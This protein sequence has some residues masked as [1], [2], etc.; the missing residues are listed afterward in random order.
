MCYPGHSVLHYRLENARDFGMQKIL[1]RDR[2]A[3]LRTEPSREKRSSRR[4]KL[5]PLQPFRQAC[6]TCPVK[7]LQLWRSVYTYEEQSCYH[8][9]LRKEEKKSKLCMIRST[10]YIIC[11]VTRPETPTT[12]PPKTKTK[13]GVPYFGQ[14][15]TCERN[16]VG[17]ALLAA[18]PHRR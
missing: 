4:K 3:C 6:R 1:V 5:S 18:A 10:R 14:D 11:I 12:I 8:I 17:M 7:R 2:F 15:P 9:D 13:D 16:A